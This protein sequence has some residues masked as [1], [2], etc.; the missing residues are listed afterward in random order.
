MNRESPNTSVATEVETG[1]SGHGDI[2]EDVEQQIAS[3]TGDV[4]APPNDAMNASELSVPNEPKRPRH[5]PNWIVWNDRLL[6]SLFSAICLVHN[7]T[8][9]RKYVAKLKEL[10]DPRCRHFEGHLLTLKQ[11]QR[12]DDRLRSFPASDTEPTDRTEIS[13][14][15]FIE[16]VKDQNPFGGITIPNQFWQLKPPL[17]PLLSAPGGAA[18]I[19]NQTR[20][21]P[22][23]VPDVGMPAET[24]P[25]QVNALQSPAHP[26]PTP[27]L[28]SLPLS[29][30]LSPAPQVQAQALTK[31]EGN[32]QERSSQE[33]DEP[34][35][36]SKPAKRRAPKPVRDDLLRNVNL[37]QPGFL[38]IDQVLA[39]TTVSRS[40]WY[41]GIQKG[42]YPSPVPL[43]GKRRVGW[44][45]Q[46]IKKLLGDLAK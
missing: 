26:E 41:D 36:N 24:A 31:H 28:A 37:D 6:V 1:S 11:W 34:T 23:S 21:V 45:T 16:F 27:M 2:A 18:S 42:T 40:G 30:P 3:D 33:P 9:G 46:D 5:Q 43:G 25:A 10:D 22:S 20:S 19:V 13:L 8:P 14:R 12:L 39:L 29:P 7:I 15:S 32:A 35:E 4:V 17:L 38:N 44:R